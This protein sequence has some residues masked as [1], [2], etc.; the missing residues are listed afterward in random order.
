MRRSALLSAIIF[1]LMV[2]GLF[3]TMVLKKPNC[4]SGMV[5]IF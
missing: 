3:A 5:P 1:T 4:P 2:I